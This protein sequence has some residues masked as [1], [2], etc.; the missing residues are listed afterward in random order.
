MI[1]RRP[2]P[3]DKIVITSWETFPGGVETAKIARL[4]YLTVESVLPIK[5]ND[6]NGDYIAWEV[7]AN[8]TDMLIGID[9]DYYQ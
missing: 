9:W 1:K 3:G 8:E 6:G 2:N 7:Y 5:L 4:P